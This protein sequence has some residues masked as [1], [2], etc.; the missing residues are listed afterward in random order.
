[1]SSLSKQNSSA[2]FHL[3]LY[4]LPMSHKKEARLHNMIELINAIIINSHKLVV[5]MSANSTLI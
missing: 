3:G 4:C 2:A 1:M 5:V